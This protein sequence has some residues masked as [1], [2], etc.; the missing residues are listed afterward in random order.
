MVVVTVVYLCALIVFYLLSAKKYSD[1]VDS[2]DKKSYPFKSLMPV[3]LFILETFKYSYNTSYDRRLI[4]AMAELYGH[5]QALMFLKIHWGNKITLMFLSLLFAFFISS[6][7]DLSIEYGVF[8]VLLPC[9]IAYSCDRD[10]FEKV[11]KRRTALQLEFPDFVNKITLLIN[12]GMTVS[13]AWEKAASDNGKQ[14]PLYME[15]RKTNQE[16]RAGVPE[17]KAYEEFAKRCRVPVITRF[18]S[19]HTDL[20]IFYGKF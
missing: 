20:E 14:T 1:I 18:I 5:K 13:R 7:S 17:Y 3:G 9:A 11:K 8:C 2:L 10:V 15:L 4:S 6:G 12:A 19:V 16:I